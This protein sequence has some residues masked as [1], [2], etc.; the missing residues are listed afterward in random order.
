M[1]DFN[2]PTFG[3]GVVFDV[4][5]KVRTEQFRMFTEALTKNRLKSYVPHFNKEAEVGEGSQGRPD[6]GDGPP[7]FK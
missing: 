2:I 5:Q 4:E 1:Y 3:R 7:A 6:S